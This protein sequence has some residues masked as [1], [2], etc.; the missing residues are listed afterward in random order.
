MRD[1]ES[2]NMDTF[3]RPLELSAPMGNV[4]CMCARLPACVR[5]CACAWPGDSDM[6][7]ALKPEFALNEQKKQHSSVI[8]GSIAN[9]SRP[10]NTRVS[11]A[12]AREAADTQPS[13]PL[14]N[15]SIPIY[16]PHP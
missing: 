11:P 12:A 13:F 1:M 14:I 7:L 8:Y 16:S 5:A 15:S 9:T 3:Q 6:P 4:G 2:N 10:Q